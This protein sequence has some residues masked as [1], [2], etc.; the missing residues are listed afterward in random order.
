METSRI[1]VARLA[2]LG[3][4]RVIGRG[5]FQNAGCLKS[6]Y[7]QLLTEGTCSF[8]VDLSACSYLDSTF[9]GVILDL[10]LKL[11]KASAGK[12]YLLNVNARNLE[13]I[14]NLG[15]DRLVYLDVPEDPNVPESEPIH[16]DPALIAARAAVKEASLEEIAAGTLTREQAGPTIL[17]AHEKL[18]DFD[19]RNVPKF[20]DVVKF[21]REDLHATSR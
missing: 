8:A 14:R 19:P 15:V 3:L 9:I 13:L 7:Q 5:S 6:F 18:M 21:L 11:K 16:T 12:L 20:K 17:D 10:G 4:V 1:L 2:G